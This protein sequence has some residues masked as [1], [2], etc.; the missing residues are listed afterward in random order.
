MK[1][2]WRRLVAL[3]GIEKFSRRQAGQCIGV[4]SDGGQFKRMP[5][6]HRLIVESNFDKGQDWQDFW[7]VHY[8]R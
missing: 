8:K 1:R 4:V 7:R 3:Q 2:P 6:R 5:V